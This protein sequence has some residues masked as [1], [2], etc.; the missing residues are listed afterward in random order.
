MKG[1]SLHRKQLSSMRDWYGQKVMIYVWKDGA[2][3]LHGGAT[4]SEGRIEIL[5]LYYQEVGV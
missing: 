5:D 3:W 4:L 2:V 1:D